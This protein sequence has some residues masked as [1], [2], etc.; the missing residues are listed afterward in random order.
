MLLAIKF[1]ASLLRLFKYL[2]FRIVGFAFYM[3]LVILGGCLLFDF[4][5]IAV[6]VRPV[7]ESGFQAYL[8]DTVLTL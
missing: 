4:F 1:F 2:L 5:K 8:I 7:L 3:I 6:E